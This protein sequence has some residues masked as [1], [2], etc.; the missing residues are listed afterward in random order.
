MDIAL[1]LTVFTT[2]FLVEL[3]DKT[4]IATLVLAT[5]YRPLYVWIGVASAFLV[6]TFVAVAFGAVM[7]KLPETPV[8]VVVA[9]LFLVAGIL[10]IKGAKDAAA[11]GDEAEEE[12]AGKAKPAEGLK[13]ISASFL[14]LFLAEW[15]DLSQLATAG[16]VARGG[17]PWAVGIAAFTALALVSGLGAAVGRALLNRISLS[18]IRAAGGVVCLIFAALMI[19][20]LA[21][22]EFPSWVPA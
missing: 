17:N 12:F 6:Q 10:L 15:G 21:G 3:P 5:K 20:G 18:T 14:I 7:S 22:V 2:L 19:A 13:A 1:M 8:H 4:F 9:L 16:F 11:E